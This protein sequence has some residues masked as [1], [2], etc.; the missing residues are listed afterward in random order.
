MAVII[1]QQGKP[2][3]RAMNVFREQQC[4][5]LCHVNA[6]ACLSYFSGY[7]CIHCMVSHDS[8]MTLMAVT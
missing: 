6:L 8:H 1:M 4:D 5:V 7:L 3:L 2:R